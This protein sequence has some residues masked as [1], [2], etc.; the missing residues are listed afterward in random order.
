MCLPQK[1]PDMRG[2]RKAHLKFPVS[3]GRQ[4]RPE[5]PEGGH[6]KGLGL[7]Q[8]ATGGQGLSM[9][10]R[11][12][13]SAGGSVVPT[14]A[15][16]VRRYAWLSVLNYAAWC[17]FW[18]FVLCLGPG[19]ATWLLELELPVNEP[20]APWP[21]WPRCGGIFGLWWLQWPVAPASLPRPFLFL[22]PCAPSPP[23]KAW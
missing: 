9:C 19:C 21:R 8:L 16:G 1:R 18:F 14:S 20:R 5:A 11:G 12:R 13:E 4:K 15:R 10:P 7:R 17:G 2:G 6:P 22:W 3:P 23:K